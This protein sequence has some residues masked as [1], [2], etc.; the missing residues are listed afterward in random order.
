M[1]GQVDDATECW[2]LWTVLGDFGISNDV[3]FASISRER[4]C[5]AIASTNADVIV[6][7]GVWTDVGKLVLS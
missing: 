2:L 3:L 4:R 6:G 7:T 1:F 5:A